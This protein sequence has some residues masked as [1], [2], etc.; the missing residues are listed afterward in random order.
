MKILYEAAARA[1]GGRDGKASTSDG[2]LAVQLAT[3]H[4]MGGSG[5]VGTNPEQLFA[6]GYAA[7]FLNAMKL[8]ATHENQPF[9]DDAGVS[10]RVGIGP[11]ESGGFG[12]AIALEVEAPGLDHEVAENLMHKAHGVCPYSNAIRGNVEV[13]LA[14]V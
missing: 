14:L 5:G 13:T 7:C 8:V 6:A 10:A 12:L 9:P 3:P 11:N 2:K 1:T 4:K